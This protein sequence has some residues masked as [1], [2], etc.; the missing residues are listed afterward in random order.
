LPGGNEVALGLLGVAIGALTPLLIG[1]RFVSL[2]VV[3]TTEAFT[4]VVFAGTLNPT[5]VM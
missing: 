5:S 4:S 3:G 2:T 1:G